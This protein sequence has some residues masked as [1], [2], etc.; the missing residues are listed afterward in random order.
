MA[1]EFDTN[2]FKCVE[3]MSNGAGGAAANILKMKMQQGLANQDL[4]SIHICK[5]HS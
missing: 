5:R 3:E 2:C 1:K 4:D